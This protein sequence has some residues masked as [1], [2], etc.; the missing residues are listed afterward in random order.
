MWSKFNCEQTSH[1]T[2]ENDA[3]NGPKELKISLAG[4]RRDRLLDMSFAGR[5][6]EAPRVEVD[7]THRAEKTDTEARKGGIHK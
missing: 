4:L 3:H 2:G 7:P 1:N 6:H 5:R